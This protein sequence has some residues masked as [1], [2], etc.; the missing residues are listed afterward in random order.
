MKARIGITYLYR[1]RHN[2]R[3]E[4]EFEKHNLFT[5]QGMT[6]AVDGLLGGGTQITNWYAGLFSGDYTPVDT[7]TA[8]TFP[9]A[10]TEVTS[11]SETSRV[12]LAF[13]A[14]SGGMI[15]NSITPAIFTFPAQVT[16]MGGFVSS[17]LTKGSTAGILL[18]ASHFDSPEIVKAGRTIELT[19]PCV[20]VNA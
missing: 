18:S 20:L 5:E 4:R 8:A 1:I 17:S 2:G 19:C 11:Y 3:I 9:G 6:H 12:L 13:G 7:D 15:D 16:L 10:A 14:A